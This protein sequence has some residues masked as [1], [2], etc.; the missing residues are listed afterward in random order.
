MKKI[1][2]RWLLLATAVQGLFCKDGPGDSN[3]LSSLETGL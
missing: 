3:R 2:S 1:D